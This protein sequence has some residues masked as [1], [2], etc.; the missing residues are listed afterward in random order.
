MSEVAV[1]IIALEDEQRAV[2]QMQVDGTTVARTVH[3]FN[4]FPVAATDPILRRIHD[5]HPNVLIIDVPKVNLAAALRAIELLHLEAPKAVLFAVGDMGQP[6][7][8]VN[9]M[10]AGAREFLERPTTTTTLLEAF[11][12]L[13]SAARKLHKNE[14]RGKVFTVV[15][16]KGGNGA[17]TVAVNTALALQAA[18]GTVALIDLAPLGH[19]ALHLNLRPSFTVMDAMRNLHRLDAS[20]LESFMVRQEGLQVLAGCTAPFAEAGAGEFARLFDL[21]VSHYR[22][23]VVDASTR[24]DANT[25]VVCDLSDMV[26]LVAHAD[27]ASLWSAARVRQY[28]GESGTGDRVRLVLNRYRKIAGF[29][30]S[31]AEAATGT[32]LFWKVPN[33]FP[34]VSAAIDRGIPVFQQNHSEIARSFS[35]LAAALSEGEESGRKSWSLFKTA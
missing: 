13:A 3:A 27:V 4:A 19:A 25:R 28:L 33:Q 1:A 29:S 9:A 32:K 10:R 23:V 31:D 14:K 18:Q 17:T 8:I 7:I 24:L 6:H 15:N 16:A 12:R 20:L 30:D 2:L 26:L 5:L 34:L 22:F 21:L 35:G 11:V